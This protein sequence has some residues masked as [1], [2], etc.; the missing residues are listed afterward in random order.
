MYG[1]AITAPANVLSAIV[2]ESYKKYILVALIHIGQVKIFIRFL[3]VIF[4]SGIVFVYKHWCS[5]LFN[6]IYACHILK[7]GCCTGLWS[8]ELDMIIT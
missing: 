1:Q 7:E 6:D 3:S 2:V 5:D 8:S 4:L